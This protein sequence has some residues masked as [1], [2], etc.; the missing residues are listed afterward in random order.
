MCKNIYFF[1]RENFATFLCI[2]S[3]CLL[4]W[5]KKQPDMYSNRWPYID[6]WIINLNC[7]TLQWYCTENKNTKCKTISFIYKCRSSLKAFT[8]LY[9]IQWAQ[10][11]T[12]SASVVHEWGKE[13]LMYLATES[14][15]KT[16]FAIYISMNRKM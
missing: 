8:R 2:A 12:Q 6:L 1:V 9:K 16:T 10:K 14:P 3:Y 7:L 5:D 13:A 15:G 4:L 11:P